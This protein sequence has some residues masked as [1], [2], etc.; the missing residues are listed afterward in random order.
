MGLI[1]E[2]VP[3]LYFC[4]VSLAT[5]EPA[6]DTYTVVIFLLGLDC[7]SFDLPSPS[8]TELPAIHLPE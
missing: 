4:G 3:F 6:L 8:S 5:F 7:R 2:G 1:V